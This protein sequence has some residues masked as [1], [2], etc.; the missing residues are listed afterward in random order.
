MESCCAIFIYPSHG[1]GVDSFVVHRF[2]SNISCYSRKIFSSIY[3][4]VAV[5][6]PAFKGVRI[7]SSI[8]LGWSLT[9]IFGRNAVFDSGTMES[10]CAIFIY[11]IHG[12]ASKYFGKLRYI[13]CITSDI[14]ERRWPF[15]IKCIL[16]LSSRSFSRS[17]AGVCR[18]FAIVHCI[19]L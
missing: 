6:A 9:F 17:L 19:Y 2:V 14:S 16:V 13:S 7:L 10:C 18:R 8:L 1:V 12:V 3:P 4:V 11:P 15:F 5:S